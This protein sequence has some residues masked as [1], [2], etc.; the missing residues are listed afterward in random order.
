METDAKERK[1]QSRF[2]LSGV[3]KGIETEE[4]AAGLA[5]VKE[6]E[7]EKDKE[8]EKTSLEKEVEKE[9]ERVNV[10]GRR[11]EDEGD[12]ENFYCY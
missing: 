7:G 12:N 8:K 4:P 6:G 11:W 1:R 3:P 2:R 10:E 9:T 5:V